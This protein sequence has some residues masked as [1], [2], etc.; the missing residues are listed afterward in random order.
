MSWR[1]WGSFSL[2]AVSVALLIVLPGIKFAERM[3]AVVAA[4]SP[5]PI[6]IPNATARWVSDREIDVE[7][8]GFVWSDTCPSI[9][10]TWAVQTRWNGAVPV[11]MRPMKGPLSARGLLPPRYPLSITPQ[12]GSALQL[13]V[14]IPEWLPP[15]DV[16]LV[17]VDD[18]VADN[19]PCASGWSGVIQ[20][21]RLQIEPRP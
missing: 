11:T 7:A 16:L 2:L 20:V 18:T 15:K 8:P 9:W 6:S 3:R 1:G 12:V 4:Q 17:E 14:T 5:P 10:V 13:R 19:E 21:F